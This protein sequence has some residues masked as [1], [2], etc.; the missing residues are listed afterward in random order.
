[1]ET[2]SHIQGRTLR[3]VKPQSHWRWEIAIYLYLAGMGAGAYVIGLSIHWMADAL[4]PSNVLLLFGVPFDISKAILLWGPI[5]VAIGA[6]FLILDLGIKKRFLYACLNPGT[7]WVARGFLILSAFIVLGLLVFGGSTV[8]LDAL[9]AAAPFHLTLEV[10]SLLLAIAT[11]LYTG[12]LLKSVKY[13]PI[14]NTVFLPLLFLVSALS[15]GSMAIIL[16]LLGY[17]LLAP[18]AA[19]SHALMDALIP[20]EQ[21]L[22]AVEAFVLAF[23]LVSRYRAQDQGETSVRLLISG[24][25]R[26]LFWGGIAATG[27]F[28]P[29]VLEYLYKQ[30]PGSPVLLIMTGLFLLSGGFFLRLGVLSAGVKEQL[31]MQKWAEIKLNL[32][33]LRR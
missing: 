19:P 22:I 14:W 24:D 30:F 12:V 4:N 11:A 21:V 32:R 31:P 16:S 5:L 6:P 33:P 2:R 28:F 23:Y 8:A 10:V 1:M 3:F 26:L 25:L 27:F 18:V 29:I 9:P 15:T 7:S 20:I 13:V 17:G